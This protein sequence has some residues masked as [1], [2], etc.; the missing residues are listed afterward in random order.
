MF[1]VLAKGQSDAAAQR[2]QTHCRVSNYHSAVQ[3]MSSRHPIVFVLLVVYM[4]NMHLRPTRYTY[5]GN[6]DAVRMIEDGMQ[7]VALDKLFSGLVLRF[8]ARDTGSFA[9]K[10]CG[11][12]CG[13]Y[14]VETQCE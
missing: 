5:D 2:A 14:K 7:A 3:T 12:R 8:P 10:K 13:F 6:V 4:R 9:N 1:S 11:L